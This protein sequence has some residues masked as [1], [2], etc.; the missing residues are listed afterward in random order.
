MRENHRSPIHIPIRHFPYLHERGP[1][2]GYFGGRNV[3]TEELTE[4]FNFRIQ[5]PTVVTRTCLRLTVHITQD[6]A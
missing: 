2:R 4:W 3:S 6:A 5:L 1:Q